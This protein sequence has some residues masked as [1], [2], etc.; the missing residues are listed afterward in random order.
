MHLTLALAALV[1]VPPDL[2]IDPAEVTHFTS[3]TRARQAAQTLR[4]PMLVILNPPAGSGRKSISIDSVR[5]TRE[6]RDLLENYV[7]TV[8]DTGTPHGQVCFDLFGQPELPRV[9]VIDK[10]QKYQIFQSS[11]EPYGQLWTTILKQHQNGEW[12]AVR[13]AS[14]AQGG[15]SGPAGAFR[16]PAYYS[17]LQQFCPT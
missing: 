6:R 9:V 2:K 8:L 7:V 11:E 16:Q 1:A 4:Q 3:Y 13:P 14:Y 17:Q 10:H 12:L 5:K 15:A